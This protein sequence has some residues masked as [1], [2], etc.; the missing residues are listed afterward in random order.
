MLVF[1]K[2]MPSTPTYPA[3]VKAWTTTSRQT[4]TLHYDPTISKLGNHYDA[5]RTLHGKFA[6]DCPHFIE[7]AYES[8]YVFVAC[9]GIGKHEHRIIT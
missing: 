2:Y 8:S 6:L 3:R 5:V 9:K 7:T 4:V 1:T